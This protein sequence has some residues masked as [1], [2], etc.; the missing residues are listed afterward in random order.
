MLTRQRDRETEREREGKRERER[1]REG[2]RA[3]EIDDINGAV[4]KA[5]TCVLSRRSFVFIDTCFVEGVLY[6]EES[7]GC[8][9]IENDD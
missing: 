9:D 6:I 7:I 5:L 3:Y 2:E 1:E 4:V 8:I